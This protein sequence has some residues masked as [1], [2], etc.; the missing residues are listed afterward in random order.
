MTA[1]QEQDASASPEAA[2]IYG[3]LLLTL[4]EPTY[5]APDLSTP[6]FYEFAELGVEWPSVAD[7]EHDIDRGRIKLVEPGEEVA[8]I[9]EHF[10]ALAEAEQ[11]AARAAEEE[12]EKLKLAAGEARAQYAR[13]ARHRL[14]E[15]PEAPP[16]SQDS[17]TERIALLEMGG[18]A[19]PVDTQPFTPV[20][21]IDPDTVRL[22]TEGFAEQVDGPEN[23]HDHEFAPMSNTCEHE[24]CD[25]DRSDD[26]TDDDTDEDEN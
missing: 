17:S 7:I 15:A 10:R 16:A 3:Q 23:D 5:E 25:Y 14:V 18:L 21:D 20:F 8:M 13:Q 1:T 4:G 12:A 22:A 6:D 24:G 11:E 26:M 2:P 9:D 19:K